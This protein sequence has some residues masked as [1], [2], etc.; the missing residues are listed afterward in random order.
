[1]SNNV[2]ETE[3]TIGQDKILNGASINSSSASSHGPHLCLVARSSTPSLESH[4]SSDDEDE[5]NEGEEDRIAYLQDKGEMIYHVLC[6]NKI[7]CSNFVEIL[8]IAIESQKRFENYENTIDKMHDLEYEYANDIGNLK[9][10]LEE[11]QT[12]EEALEETFALELSSVKIGR[13]H[14]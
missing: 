11:E 13:A 9:E 3:D 4:I 5:D 10:A 8:T 1:M 12:T 14:V 6:K 2:E 7:A